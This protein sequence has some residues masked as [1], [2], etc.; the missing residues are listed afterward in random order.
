MATIR[1]LLDHFLKFQ[2]RF[3]SEEWGISS[4]DQGIL[5]DFLKQQ[6]DAY[7]AMRWMGICKN[8]RLKGDENQEATIG[9]LPRDTVNI[10]MDK[11]AHD[12]DRPLIKEVEREIQQEIEL[13][14]TQELEGWQSLPY[15]EEI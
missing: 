2:T 1:V 6:L 3:L 8:W 5:K 14:L 15:S 10:I 13:R 12:G 7:Q 9:K 11:L 4:Q